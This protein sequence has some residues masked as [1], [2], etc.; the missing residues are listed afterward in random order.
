MKENGKE[1]KSD[2]QSGG[3]TSCSSTIRSVLAGRSAFGFGDF[4]AR[5]DSIFVDLVYRTKRTT[6]PVS[7]RGAQSSGQLL[8]LDVP[9]HYRDGEDR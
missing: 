3:R 1:F 5:I 7:V 6:T 8:R 4:A 2:W 9:G